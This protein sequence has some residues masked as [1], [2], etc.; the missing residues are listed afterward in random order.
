MIVIT[1]TNNNLKPSAWMVNKN[2]WI[3]LFVS[4]INFFNNAVVYQN[5]QKIHIDYSNVRCKTKNKS[6]CILTISALVSDENDWLFCSIP[7]DLESNLQSI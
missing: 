3:Q 7:I 1:N 4:S 5:T 6:W 2:N